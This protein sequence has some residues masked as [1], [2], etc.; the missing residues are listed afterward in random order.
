MAMELFMYFNYLAYTDNSIDPNVSLHVLIALTSHLFYF[1]YLPNV[2]GKC[3]LSCGPDGIL[4]R[5]SLTSCS[6]DV[7]SLHCIILSLICA[8]DPLIPLKSEQSSLFSVESSNPPHV[9]LD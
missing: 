1:H 2:S 7:A 5:I 4:G 9:S 3:P 6:M 8:S